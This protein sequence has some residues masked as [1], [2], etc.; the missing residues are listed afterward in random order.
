[1]THSRTEFSLPFVGL[2][3]L[4]MSDPQLHVAPF[5]YAIDFVLPLGTDV[6]AGANGIVEEVRLESRMGGMNPQ[7][8]DERW[9]NY[10]VLRH[11]YGEFSIYGHLAFQCSTLKVGDVVSQGQ[12]IAATGMS[13][14]MT[15][16]HLHF[17]VYHIATDG[18][19]VSV[20][21]TFHIPFHIHRPRYSRELEPIFTNI[22]LI[23]RTWSQSAGAGEIPS[24]MPAP[25][26]H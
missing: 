3:C 15:L 17:H 11:K 21:P 26:N 4:A 13:G 19:P 7:Y 14:L 6:L 9:L 24:P 20:Y 10:I 23:S 2:R 18:L 5:Q 8:Q 16:P 1:M 22:K 25:E 12:R